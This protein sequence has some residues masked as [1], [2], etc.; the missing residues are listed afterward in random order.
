MKKIIFLCFAIVFASISCKKDSEGTATS[1]ELSITKNGVGQSGIE[2]K[3]YKEWEMRTLIETQKTN[4]NGIINFVDLQN[5]LTFTSN[6]S[7]KGYVC[8]IA[9]AGLTQLFLNEGVNK[10][11]IELDR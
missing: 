5:K 1:L 8:T 9:G 3:M 6:D 4:A 2:I 11:T 10:E 7:V